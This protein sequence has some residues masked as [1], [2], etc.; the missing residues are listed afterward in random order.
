MSSMLE[1]VNHLSREIGAR[2]A[3]TEEER[4]AAMYIAENIQ[5]RSGLPFDIEDFEGAKG[6]NRVV[7][8]LSIVSAVLLLLAILLPVMTIP[9]LVLTLAIAII[10]VLEYM[11]RPILSN[12]FR[13][14][15]S[16]NVVAKYIPAYSAESSQTQRKRKIIFVSHYDSGRSL[17]ENAEMVLNISYWSK[18][19]AIVVDCLIAVFLIIK[20]FAFP[21]TSGG[22]TLFCVVFA[23][24]LALIC[25]MPSLLD[26][27]K[28]RLLYNEGANCNASGNAALIEI[29]KQLGTGA[30]S[31]DEDFENKRPS[32]VVHGENVARQAGVIPTGANVEY[33]TSSAQ[34]SG[35]PKAQSDIK[36]DVLQQKE[37]S[38]EN[39]KAAIAAFTAP[40]A[41]RA[42]YDDEGNVVDE[43]L[44]TSEEKPAVSSVTI[45]D[46]TAAREEVKADTTAS[47]PAYKSE[48]KASGD[49]PD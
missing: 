35:S 47:I 16:Q 30:Y 27:Y 36:E 46:A 40:R 13:Y 3:G 34:A 8:I 11:N 41:P 31:T 5:K 21:E 6:S 4:L 14:G 7:N 33:E 22:L 10:C 44:K 29:A 12:F 39:A 1:D 28:S 48:V 23:I 49:V 19:L 38:L 2:P 17:P 32:P 15:I 43:G 24:V 25:V 26:V 20:I 42:K 18:F 37:Q 9:S 45:D